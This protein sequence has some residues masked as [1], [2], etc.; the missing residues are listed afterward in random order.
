MG[1]MGCLRDVSQVTHVTSGATQMTLQV[2]WKHGALIQRLESQRK[3]WNSGM[4][5]FPHWDM[6]K[7]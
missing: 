5:W 2:G 6:V 1:S 3:V 7:Q 4:S